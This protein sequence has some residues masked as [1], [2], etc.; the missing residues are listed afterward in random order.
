MS[1]KWTGDMES[2]SDEELREA[3]GWPVGCPPLGVSSGNKG[4]TSS[5]RVSALRLVLVILRRCGLTIGDWRTTR[6]DFCLEGGFML[7]PTARLLA[8]AA[9]EAVL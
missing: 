3:S 5:E 2:C 1:D 6:L 4:S 9:A 8:I 7:L